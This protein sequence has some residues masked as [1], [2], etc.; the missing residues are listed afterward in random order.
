MLPPCSERNDFRQHSG[1]IICMASTLSAIAQQ[2]HSPYIASKGGI[3]QLMKAIA[4]EAGPLWDQCQCSWTYLRQHRFSIDDSL[5][6]SKKKE[7]ILN[8]IPMH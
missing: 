3:L 8:K 6:D 4:L 5:G 2:G 7:E 1:K